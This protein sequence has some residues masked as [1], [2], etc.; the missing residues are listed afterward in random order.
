MVALVAALSFTLPVMQARG[1]SAGPDILRDSLQWR[2]SVRQQSAAW[3][4][5][6]PAMLADPSV[7]AAIWPIV[8]AEAEPQVVASG[9]AAP[10]SRVSASTSDT[11]SLSKANGAFST[12]TAPHWYSATSR[13]GRGE[14][15][16]SNVV[17]K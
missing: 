3:I 9:T 15:C 1:C 5:M 16:T 12:L 17:G 14:S 10:G 8:R 2:V 7:W 6:R 11:A 4:A 13:N